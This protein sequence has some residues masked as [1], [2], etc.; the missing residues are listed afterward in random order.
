MFSNF[1]NLF[2]DLCIFLEECY[3]ISQNLGIAN[4]IFLLIVNLISLW[5]EKAFCVNS[6]IWKFL[7]YHLVIFDKSSMCVYNNMNAFIVGCML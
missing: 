1:L 4:Y 3:L 6:I 5:S 7:S 2:L